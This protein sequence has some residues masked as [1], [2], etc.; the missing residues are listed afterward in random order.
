MHPNDK[1]YPILC[2]GDRIFYNTGIGE[3]CKKIGTIKEVNGEEYR[4]VI[5]NDPTE[6]RW[7]TYA[8][9]YGTH[10]VLAEDEESKLMLEEMDTE[11]IDKFLAS[12]SIT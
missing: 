9:D 7:R 5:D 10:F 11:G 8:S 1:E 12:F 3:V 6:H 4:V 2:V